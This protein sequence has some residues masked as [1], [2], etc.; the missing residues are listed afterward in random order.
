MLMRE[1]VM[2]IIIRSV[3]DKAKVIAM[4]ALA[5]FLFFFNVRRANHCGQ[6][7]GCI[8]AYWANFWLISYAD[9]YERRAL[10]GQVM[11]MLFG[12]SMSYIILNVIAMAF[13]LFI[14]SLV[15]YIFFPRFQAIG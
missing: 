12:E 11:R 1:D 2:S 8:D 3:S 4:L 9:G 13:V 7:G 15:Y 10:V 6:N 14:L 5:F